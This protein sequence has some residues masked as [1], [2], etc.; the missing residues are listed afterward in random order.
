MPRVKQAW[1]SKAKQDT[2]ANDTEEEEDEERRREQARKANC[3]FEP[4]S[5]LLE[6]HRQA[7]ARLERARSKGDRG[8]EYDATLALAELQL[9]RGRYGEALRYANLAEGLSAEVTT[10][11]SAVAVRVAVKAMLAEDKLV[12][13]L[14]LAEGE[15]QFNKLSGNKKAEAILGLALAEVLLAGGRARQAVKVLDAS[16]AA[17]RALGEDLLAA[18]ALKALSAASLEIE[19]S[20]YSKRSLQA[21]EDALKLYRKYGDRAEELKSLLA[22][23]K[24]HLARHELHD[25]YIFAHGALELSRQRNNLKEEAVALRELSAVFLARED[26]EIAIDAVQDSVEICQHLTDWA[27]E[28]SS[29]VALNNAFQGDRMT[30]KGLEC[31]EQALKLARDLRDRKR[32]IELLDQ[33]TKIHHAMDGLEIM[34]TELNL[35]R[36]SGDLRRELNAYR[37]IALL[38]VSQGKS[39]EALRAT[40]DAAA[41]MKAAADLPGE[42]AAMQLLAE[43]NGMLRNHDE[44]LKAILQ[45]R[46]LFHQAKDVKGEVGA[47]QMAAQIYETNGMAKEALASC[48]EVRKVYKEAGWKEEEASTLMDLSPV[49]LHKRGP[50]EAMSTAKEAVALYREMKDREGEAN[51]MI[52][53][54][55]FQVPS[56]AMRTVKVARQTFQELGHSGGEAQA[57]EVTAKLHIHQDHMDGAL[58]CCREAVEITQKAADRLGEAKATEVLAIVHLELAKKESDLEGKVGEKVVDDAL[59]VSMQS[60]ALWEELGDF[61]GQAAALLQLSQ[62]HRL[63]KDGKLALDTAK[64]ALDISQKLDDMKVEGNC[65]LALAESY[66]VNDEG[67]QAMLVAEDAKTFFDQLGDDEGVVEAET[68]HERAKDMVENPKKFS[69]P[70][71]RRAEAEQSVQSRYGKS[72]DA[73]RSRPQPKP[74]PKTSAAKKTRG[75][76]SSIVESIEQFQQEEDAAELRRMELLNIVPDPWNAPNQE[77]RRQQMAEAAAA[78]TNSVSLKE[79][80]PKPKAKPKPKPKPPAAE[81]AESPALTDG[82]ESLLRVLAI[83]RPDWNSRERSLVQEKL[84]GVQIA[85]A[86]QLFDVIR[87]DG[88]KGINTRLK[89]AGFKGL[90]PATLEA[91]KAEADKVEAPENF[92]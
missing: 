27:G 92:Y 31:L 16:L 40:A 30:N 62:L 18:G 33:M 38:N 15:R 76:F 41:V 88:A 21:A 26:I 24:A 55:S 29:L 10:G 59:W 12:D 36:A 25:A 14:E 53:L 57:L 47:L 7:K 17:F 68:L 78:A 43:V 80:E 9:L 22:I 32:I 3:K 48:H 81:G 1:A 28:I 91:L 37:K 39:D 4:S 71:P 67:S 83:V 89:S 19:G 70:R 86:Q 20:L 74:Q 56:E 60:L 5:A 64:A 87:S 51:A 54:A 34:E 72:V 61:A 90:L 50:W 44:A 66:L 77:L 84:A 23:S 6:Q 49:L 73:S 13:A 79:E 11:D 46:T 8:E 65:I 2:Q 45:A 82:Q 85:S 42:A 69:E 35:A 75:G 63:S 58:E 52:I